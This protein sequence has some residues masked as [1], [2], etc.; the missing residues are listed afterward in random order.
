M[1][2]QAAH[3]RATEMFKAVNSAF[4]AFKKQ[5]ETRGANQM[6]GSRGT[7]GGGGGGGGSSGGG[8]GG[9]GRTG[10]ARQTRGRGRRK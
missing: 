5:N 2:D 7:D 3:A 6:G 10:G 8:G 9:G 1:N 4:E